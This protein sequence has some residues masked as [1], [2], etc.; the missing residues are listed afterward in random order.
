MGVSLVE[1]FPGCTVSRLNGW[2]CVKINKHKDG[3]W[4]LYAMEKGARQHV[5][6]FTLEAVATYAAK[7][8]KADAAGVERALG[9]AD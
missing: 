7:L 5:M 9:L 1:H 2:P 4:H 8:P 6:S 3:S